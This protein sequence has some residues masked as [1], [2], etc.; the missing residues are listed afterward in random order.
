MT[1]TAVS[2]TTHTIVAV[3]AMPASGPGALSG[4]EAVCSCGYRMGTSLSAAE[5]TRQGTA[6]VAYMARKVTAR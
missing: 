2:T 6:H 4:H 5:A 3:E 1:T